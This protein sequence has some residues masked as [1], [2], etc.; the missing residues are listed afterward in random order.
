MMEFAVHA[1]ALVATVLAFFRV[2]LWFGERFEVNAKSLKRIAERHG[3]FVELRYSLNTSG[4][5]QEPKLIHVEFYTLS[6]DW[7]FSHRIYNRKR[8]IVIRPAERDHSEKFKLHDYRR[9]ID[10]YKNRG[11]D[12]GKQ[13]GVKFYD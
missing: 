8:A 4:Y 6:R 3:L 5:R 9:I 2:L 7:N 10:A 13:K 1:I 11:I 12:V